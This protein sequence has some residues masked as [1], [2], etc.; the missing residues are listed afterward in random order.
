MLF[1]GKFYGCFMYYGCTI[2]VYQM[3]DHIVGQILKLDEYA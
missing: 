2:D 3:L 1:H